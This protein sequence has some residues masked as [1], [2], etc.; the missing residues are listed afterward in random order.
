[1]HT[2]RRQEIS[3]KIQESL[4]LTPL[5]DDFVAALQAT[6]DSS[7]PGPSQITYGLIKQLPPVILQEVYQLLSDIWECRLTPEEWKL[8]W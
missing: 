2:P 8:K 3:C 4:S 6:K 7:A 1:M 5:Y